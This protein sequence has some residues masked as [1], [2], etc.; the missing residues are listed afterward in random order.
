MTSYYEVE[1]VRLG[2]TKIQV[3]ELIY[4]KNPNPLFKASGIMLNMLKQEYGEGPFVLT[5]IAILNGQAYLN[6]IDKHGEEQSI[7]HIFFSK[8]E[9]EKKEKE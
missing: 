6:F 1:E 5:R 7:S 3:G 4:W 9:S 8:T 2:E